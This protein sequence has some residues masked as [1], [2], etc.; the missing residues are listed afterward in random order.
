MPNILHIQASPRGGESFSAR[1]AEALLTELAHARSDCTVETL[2]LF[3][4]D[5][6]AFAAPAARAK[7]AV[8]GGQEPAD[9][10]QQAWKPVLEAVE[11]FR[12]ADAYVLSTG[13]WN[14]SIPYRLKQYIDV[15][16]QPGL[17]FSFSPESGYEGLVL[18]KPGAVIV[19]RGGAYGEG[20]GM[21]SHDFQLPY[22]RTVL[23]F[24][25]LTD[26]TEIVIEP[27]LAAGP[28]AAGRALQRAVE[29]ARAA[30]REIA[31]K[32]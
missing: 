14:F 9:E 20:S 15:I 2:D 12:A 18:G 22:L 27:T 8:M 4:A 7:Y 24:I 29:K 28:D 6:P 26:L 21:G 1:T 11:H 16:V 17:T 30:A 5:L 3:A 19:A 10:A 32:L 13:M 31:G 25:G 23:G